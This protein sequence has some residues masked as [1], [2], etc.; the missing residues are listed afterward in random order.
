MD[1]VSIERNKVW[2]EMVRAKGR[3]DDSAAMPVAILSTLFQWR[4]RSV[5][6]CFPEFLR[7]RDKIWGVDCARF[8][9]GEGDVL[10]IR[11][12]Q[13]AAF[14]RGHCRN[15]QAFGS[16]FHVFLPTLTPPTW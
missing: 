1:L 11:P 2:R 15:A 8:E 7:G 9:V 13:R 14:A 12:I 4:P 10:R 5:P 16:G 6:S 3:P